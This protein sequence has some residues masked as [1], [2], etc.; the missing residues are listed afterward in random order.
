MPSLAIQEQIAII[1]LFF[2]INFQMVG[3]GRHPYVTTYSDLTGQ[4]VFNGFVRTS[5]KRSNNGHSYVNARVLTTEARKM[6]IQ[7]HLHLLL[8][9]V[10]AQM[11]V[12][13][14]PS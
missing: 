4:H 7:A 8:L 12:F 10:V 6:R 11:H 3:K 13:P 14:S 1:H 5:Q 2:V 9:G